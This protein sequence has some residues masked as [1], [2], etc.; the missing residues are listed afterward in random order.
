MAMRRIAGHRLGVDQGDVV[1]FS[2][3]E[4]GGAMWEGEGRRHARAF[5]HFSEPFL[6]PPAV[7]VSLTMWDISNAANARA[8]VVAEDVAREGFGILFRTWGDTKIA[9]VRVGWTAIGPLRDED[10]WDVP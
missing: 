2:D 7:Q 5:V 6:E 1:L 3:F 4:T 10:D 8:D 9:R